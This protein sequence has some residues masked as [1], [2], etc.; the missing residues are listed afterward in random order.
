M[1]GTP[2]WGALVI[3]LGHT[4]YGYRYSYGSRGRYGYGYG[5]GVNPNSA[6]AAGESAAAPDAGD[7]KAKA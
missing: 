4:P 6:N 2:I 5:Y 1:M 3:G 7:P